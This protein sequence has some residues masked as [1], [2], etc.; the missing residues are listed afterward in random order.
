MER[1]Q[2]EE[3]IICLTKMVYD[4]YFSM[5]GV[6]NTAMDLLELDPVN[7]Q[8]KLKKNDIENFKFDNK[9][10]YI[11]SIK[12]FDL[13]YSFLLEK[14]VP[15]SNI[16]K[17]SPEPLVINIDDDKMMIQEKVLALPAKAI[18]ATV[19]AK[20]LLMFSEILD[21]HDIIHFLAFGTL[22][23]AYRDKEFILHDY[24]IDIGM[25][26][27]DFKR[28]EKIFRELAENGFFVIRY[29]PNLISL[30]KDSEYIDIYFFA[31]IKYLF[32]KIWTC[33]NYIIPS[34]HMVRFD[35]LQF[36][37]KEFFIPTD[38]ENLFVFYYGENWKTPI[39]NKHAQ[40]AD[41]IKP[42][43][44]GRFISKVKS[45]LNIDNRA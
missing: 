24:D 35:R 44:Y 12:Y 3:V 15:F 7:N 36:K 29:S 41:V 40:P 25:F 43:Y 37:G 21:K 42:S 2:Q 26:K 13:F 16:I 1:L 8:L 38:P 22:L 4:D 17:P 30:M 28:M 33:D 6:F 32:K 10:F 27:R 19:A 39:K 23:G 20:N 45:L 34:R 9:K 14:K 31:E 11:H 18:D 5:A